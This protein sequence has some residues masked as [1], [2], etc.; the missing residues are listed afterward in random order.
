VAGMAGKF[1]LQSMCMYDCMYECREGA[2]DRVGV[3]CV[4]V[5]G[6]GECVSSVGVCIMCVMN[7]CDE[8]VCGSV[9]MHVYVMSVQV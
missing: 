8:C 9:C 7:V 3:V 1:T 6:G 4:C 2:S 5:W